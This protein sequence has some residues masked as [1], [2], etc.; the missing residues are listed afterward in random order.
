VVA[1]FYN[2]NYN[3]EIILK[4]KIINASISSEKLMFNSIGWILKGSYAKFII[5]GTITT[6]NELFNIEL[7]WWVKICYI[8]TF[9]LNVLFLYFIKIYK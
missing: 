3:W 4:N 5:I 7:V 6:P 9:L 8:A 1:E 2:C